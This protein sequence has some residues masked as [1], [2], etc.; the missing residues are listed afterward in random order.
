M[1][2]ATDGPTAVSPLPAGECA[3]EAPHELTPTELRG[4]LSDLGH[5]RNGEIV[6]TRCR[7]SSLRLSRLPGLARYINLQQLVV[8]DNDLTDLTAVMHMPQLVYLSARHNRLSSA[9]FQSLAGTAACLERLHLDH[10]CLTSLGGLE[11]LPYIT[12]LT[13][14]HNAIE[15]VS[16]RCLSAAQRLMRLRLDHNCISAIDVHAFT[17]AQHLRVLE[18]KHNDLTDVSFV[19]SVSGE[20]ERVVLADNHIEHLDNAMQHLT[21]LTVLDL[22]RNTLSGLEELRALR[23]LTALRVLLF[24]GN[25]ALAHL[26]LSYAAAAGGGDEEEEEGVGRSPNTGGRTEYHA[27]VVM[28]DDEG[29]DAALGTSS[30]ADERSRTFHPSRSPSEDGRGEIGG[31]GRPAE[32]AH[33]PRPGGSKGIYADSAAHHSS[34]PVARAATAAAAAVATAP[35]TAAYVA[36]AA[37]ETHGF[38]R[39]VGSVARDPELSVRVDKGREIVALPVAE[40][41]F[42][43]T[44]ALLPHLLQLNE[45]PVSPADVARANFLFSSPGA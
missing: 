32:V 41:M 23:H 27:E 14:S 11:A 38:V 3:A 40:Q 9:V 33:T 13:C 5:N 31:G 24:D 1:P 45:Q 44:L 30:H 42:L 26:P 2:L 19:S 29:D 16:A 39:T 18:L 20:V 25:D 4:A 15:G 12:D 37:P 28:S 35:T 21:G 36:L 22:R 10:N 7:L 43:W 6:Y 17:A 8:D 34:P